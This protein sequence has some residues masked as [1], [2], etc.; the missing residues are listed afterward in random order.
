MSAE[1]SQRVSVA[2][3]D[4]VCGAV[5]VV[6]GRN[7]HTFLA[8]VPTEGRRRVP[9]RLK[10]SPGAA[11]S[12]ELPVSRRKPSIGWSS[13]GTAG[14]HAR[15]PTSD[16]WSLAEEGRGKI[17]ALVPKTARPLLCFAHPHSFP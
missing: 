5:G 4:A 1:W 3:S 6:K 8:A 7:A 13:E 17:P 2:M 16:T 11:L 10:G 15:W 14:E 9:G 12:V